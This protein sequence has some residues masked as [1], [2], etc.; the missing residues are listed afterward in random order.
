LLNRLILVPALAAGL[1]LVL[2]ASALAAETFGA[3]CADCHEETV[4]IFA[5]NIHSKIA[6]YGEEGSCES[7][8]AGA[9]NHAESGDP[10]Q[11]VNLGKVEAEKASETCL[12][13]HVKDKNQ[14][15]WPGSVHESQQLGCTSCHSVHG[16][17]EKLL[18]RAD[19]KDVCF[20]CHFDVRADMLKRSKHPLRDSSTPSMEGKMTCSD[21]HNP[22]GARSEALI[23]AKSINDKCYECHFEKKAPLLWE[24]SPVKEDCLICHNPHGSSNDKLLVTKVPRLCQECHMQGRHQSGTLAENSVFAFNR[25]CL[26]CH[27]QVHG[28]N[29]PS[30]VVLQR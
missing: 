14:M 29:N 4:K 22:H 7:C 13:C 18:A 5:G 30:G 16:G 9:S 25:G 3:A 15:F 27:P 2:G 20:T 23:D 10:S 11:V 12:E 1:L 21:C 28:S 26:N 8:H 24:H 19:Q 17:Q 6:Y